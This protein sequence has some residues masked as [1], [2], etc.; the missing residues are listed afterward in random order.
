L[1][2]DRN[3]INRRNVSTEVDKKFSAC[4]QF[5]KMEIEARVIAAALDSMKIPP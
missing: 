5:F 4:K 1:Y 3:H 2:A